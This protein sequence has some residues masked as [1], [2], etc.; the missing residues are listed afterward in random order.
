[1]LARDSGLCG[2]RSKNG[3]KPGNKQFDMTTVKSPLMFFVVLSKRL[4]KV[5]KAIAWVFKGLYTLN[6]YCLK[7]SSNLSTFPWVSDSE[8]KTTI[9]GRHSQQQR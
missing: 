4:F 8:L 2:H 9:F 3:G 7:R 6:I 5:K 1:M